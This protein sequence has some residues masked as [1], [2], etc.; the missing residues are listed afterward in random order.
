MQLIFAFSLEELKARGEINHQTPEEKKIFILPAEEEI[1]LDI[2]ST[3]FPCHPP[4]AARPHLLFS[5]EGYQRAGQRPSYW[6]QYL[7]SSCQTRTWHPLQSPPYW[8]G[9]QLL[10]SCLRPW[11]EPVQGT[12]V[13]RMGQDGVGRDGWLV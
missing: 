5:V 11:D 12:E 1:I 4:L 9:I 13:I 2:N 7:S 10:W 6:R 3:Q 8:T